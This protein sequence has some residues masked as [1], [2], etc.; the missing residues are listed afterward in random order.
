MLKYF[1]LSYSFTKRNVLEEKKINSENLFK[2]FI[3][4][5][6]RNFQNYSSLL[7][8]K[9]NI[10][11]DYKEPNERNYLIIL[12]II[13]TSILLVIHWITYKYFIK[14]NF[15][16]EDGGIKKLFQEKKI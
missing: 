10:T 6:L 5:Y 14:I 7:K 3:L 12:Y 13:S 15:K 1:N 11:P 16:E 4:D 9:I 8:E 2:Q